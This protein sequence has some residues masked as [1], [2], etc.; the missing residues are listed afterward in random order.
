[1]DK[2]LKEIFQRGFGLKK[3][4]MMPINKKKIAG[5]T[6]LPSQFELGQPQ[7]EVNTTR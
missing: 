6:F 7:E 5:Q 1:M 2:W 4:L 3:I